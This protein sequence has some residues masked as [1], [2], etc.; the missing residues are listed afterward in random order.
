MSRFEELMLPEAMDHN[1]GN[2]GHGDPDNTETATNNEAHHGCLKQR[3]IPI[4][5]LVTSGVT[6]SITS[7]NNEESLQGNAPDPQI[8]HDESFEEL[9]LP[10]AMDHHNLETSVMVILTIK[11]QQ[12][13]NSS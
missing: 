11:K 5:K 10:E 2:A 8:R 4:A 12:T 1:S 13:M 7:V 3:E 6:V 9:M